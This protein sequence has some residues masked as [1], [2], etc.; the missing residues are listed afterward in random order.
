[1][2][3]SHRKSPSHKSCRATLTVRILGTQHANN[4]AD[5]RSRC[6]ELQRGTDQKSAQA[7][8]LKERDYSHTNLANTTMANRQTLDDISLTTICSVNNAGVRNL[9]HARHED[10]LRSFREGLSLLSAHLSRRENPQN[11]QHVAADPNPAEQA[12]LGEHQEMNQDEGQHDGEER[13]IQEQDHL[14]ALREQQQDEERNGEN[15]E[16]DEDTRNR[17]P[18]LARPQVLRVPEIVTAEANDYHET[19]TFSLYQGAFLLDEGEEE[20]EEEM[21]ARHPEYPHVVMLAILY[22]MGLACHA[23]ALCLEV[24]QHGRGGGQTTALAHDHIY[25]HQHHGGPA[26]SSIFFHE[27]RG[28]YRKVNET[29]Q[30]ALGL[31]TDHFSEIAGILLATSNNMGHLHA[32]RLDQDGMD[33]SLHQLRAIVHRIDVEGIAPMDMEFFLMALFLA[34][35]LGDEGRPPMAPSA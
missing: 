2:E 17:D 5:L 35:Q 28:L 9:Q 11:P 25:Q 18:T 23:L 16:T 33:D 1:M 3:F 21:F 31:L 6:K 10:A 32:L 4:K 29:L 24:P 7:G 30:V 14:S 20:D 15:V 26:S 8:S 19:T 13:R 27:A 12:A 34:G 22:N